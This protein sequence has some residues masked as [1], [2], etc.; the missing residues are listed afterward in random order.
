MREIE[1][2]LLFS[3]KDREKLKRNASGRER[4]FFSNANS[5]KR[6]TKKRG[7]RKEEENK[8]QSFV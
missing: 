8:R 4:K 5:L 2:F 7:K 3:I 1:I 6:K